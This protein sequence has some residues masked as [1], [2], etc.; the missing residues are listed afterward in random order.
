MKQFLNEAAKAVI[1]LVGAGYA[2]FQ[3][4]SSELSEQGAH[5]TTAEWQNIV[6]SA[7]LVAIGVWA[8]PNADAKKPQL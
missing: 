5:V 3:L 2:A 6:V 1:A 8:V 4:A 7:L